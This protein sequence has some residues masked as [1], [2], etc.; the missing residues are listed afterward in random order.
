MLVGISVGSLE[1]LG[2]HAGIREVRDSIKQKDKSHRGEE[3]KL[4]TK[5]I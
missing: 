4:H 1:I 5:F 2:S 3:V